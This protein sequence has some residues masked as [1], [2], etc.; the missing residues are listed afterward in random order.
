MI[1]LLYKPVGLLMGAAGAWAAG[2][3]VKKIWKATTGDDDTPDP[4]DPDSQWKA[5]II[6]AALQGAIFAIVKAAVERGG[7]ASARR[8]GS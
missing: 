7:A 1:K 4:S 2:A 3:A 6:S 8:I 5:V